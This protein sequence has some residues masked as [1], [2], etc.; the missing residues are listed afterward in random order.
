MVLANPTKPIADGHFTARPGPL[1]GAQPAGGK[2]ILVNPVCEDTSAS[3][4]PATQPLYKT[5]YGR[6]WRYAEIDQ[7][8]IAQKAFVTATQTPHV[9]D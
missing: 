6:F 2:L 5:R 1:S 8:F 4:L 7:I 3:A 9:H